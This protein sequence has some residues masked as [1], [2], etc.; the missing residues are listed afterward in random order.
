[1]RKILICDDEAYVR[2]LLCDYLR[3]TEKLLGE[4]F[5][6]VCCSSGEAMLEQAAD[7]DI[8]LLDIGMDTMSGMEAAHTLRRR[9]NNACLIFITSMTEYALEGYS[10][11]AFGFLKKPVQF[12][13]FFQQ[14]EDALSTLAP[15]AGITVVLK[16]GLELFRMNSREILYIEVMGHNIRV[17]HT[18]GDFQCPA[19]LSE[20]EEALLPHGFFRCHKSY[21][22]NLDYIQRIL[23]NSLLMTNQAD[24]PVSKYRRKEFMTAF[25]K[26]AGGTV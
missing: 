16:N 2:D 13:T 25:S 24:I 17:H 10:V 20:L 23:P 11:H 18:H 4:E 9:S 5:Q 14:I 3:Q 1:M 22:I 8:V 15:R 7:A 12:G 6:I 26:F 19:R 21:L